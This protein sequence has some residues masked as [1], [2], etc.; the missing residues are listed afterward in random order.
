M[1]NFGR[2]NYKKVLELSILLFYKFRELDNFKNIKL[3]L[4]GGCRIERM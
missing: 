1:K 4:I 3:K 2:I